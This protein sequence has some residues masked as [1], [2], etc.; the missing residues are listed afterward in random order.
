MNHPQASHLYSVPN[1]VQL[2]SDHH[3]ADGEDLLRVGV[4]RNVAEPDAR[5]AAQCEVQSGDVFV[6]DRRTGAGVAVV[7]R[8]A[9]LLSQVVQP[10]GLR[11]RPLHKAD[12]V[13]NAGQ[14]VGDEYKGAHE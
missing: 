6:F 11:V 4:W 5:Q 13:P 1:S 10:A 12:G 3:D 9:Q 14:P 8:L 7:V 2:T